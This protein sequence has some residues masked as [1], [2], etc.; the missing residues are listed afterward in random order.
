MRARET[1]RVWFRATVLA[2]LAGCATGVT[3][4]DHVGDQLDA[5][6]NKPDAHVTPGDAPIQAIDAPAMTDAGVPPADAFTPPPDAASQLFCTKNSECTN[7][8]ECCIT[9][10]GP[11]GFCGSGI[12]IGNNCIPQ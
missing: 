10:G 12:P 7:A 8:G 4:Q 2:L 5:S 1:M 11:M 3:P 6:S 9:L